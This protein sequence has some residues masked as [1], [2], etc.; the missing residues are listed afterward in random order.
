MEAESPRRR[1]RQ[2]SAISAPV[3]QFGGKLTPSSCGNQ[4]MACP[5]W[6]STPRRSEKRAVRGTRST[7]PGR[8]WEGGHLQRWQEQKALWGTPWEKTNSS[9]AVYS[10]Q[11][12]HLL[13]T[14]LLITKSQVQP[15]QRW[16]LIPGLLAQSAPPPFTKTWKRGFGVMLLFFFLLWAV[17]NNSQELRI[18]R[19][20]YSCICVHFQFSDVWLK[21]IDIT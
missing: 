1:Q 9:V 3:L 11:T 13:I 8:A 5:F 18:F 12:S 6:Q 10:W 17:Q 20:I 14:D 7:L 21:D 4:C 2:R 15:T 16:Q 19:P